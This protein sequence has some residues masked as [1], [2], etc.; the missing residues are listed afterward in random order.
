MSA[1]TANHCWVCRLENYFTS[2]W[3]KISHFLR[4]SRGKNSFSH[5]AFPFYSCTHSHGFFIFRFVILINALNKKS[6]ARKDKRKKLFALL[7]RLEVESRFT[8]LTRVFVPCDDDGNEAG[9]RFHF[10]YTKYYIKSHAKISISYMLSIHYINISPSIVSE[11]GK[12]FCIE[13]INS[14]SLSLV[15]ELLLLK[16]P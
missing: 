5:G 11:N 8:T 12:R 2:R 1:A 15:F 13:T 9:I 16:R 10:F 14:C 3:I 4:S 7:V 6:D